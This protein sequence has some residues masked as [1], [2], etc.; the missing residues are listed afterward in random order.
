MSEHLDRM[1]QNSHSDTLKDGQTD[2][3]APIAIS[4]PLAKEQHEIRKGWFPLRSGTSEHASGTPAWQ[5]AIARWEMVYGSSVVA[6]FLAA[7]AATVVMGI[8]RLAWGVPSL[9][10]LVGER[11]LPL[12]PVDLFV[13]MLVFFAPDSKTSPLGLALLGQLILGTA[14]GPVAVKLRQLIAIRMPQAQGMATSPMQAVSRYQTLGT[15]LAVGSIAL[16]ELF[17]TVILFWPVLGESLLGNPVDQ[18]RAITIAACSVTFFTYALV[19]WIAGQWLGSF[20]TW[21][22]T[23]ILPTD[24]RG[25]IPE[26][27]PTAVRASDNWHRTIRPIIEHSANNSPAESP[28]T[29]VAGVSGAGLSGRRAFIKSGVTVLAVASGTFALQQV[30]TDVL[31]RSNLAYEGMITPLNGISAITPINEFYVVSKNV[32]D[33]SVIASHWQLELRGLIAEEH[34]WTYA[35]IQRLPSETRAITIQCISNQVGAGL[36]STGIWQGVELAT[37]LAQQ[38]GVRENASHVVFTSVDG[39][40][41]SLPLA[42][43]L[44]AKALLAW[45]VNGVALPPAHGFPLR[46]IVPGRY[47][48]QSPKWLTRI[49]LVDHPVKGFYQSQGWSDAPVPTTSRFDAPGTFGEANSHI[50]LAPVTVMGIAYAGT[51]GIQK[52]EVSTDNGLTWNM[53]TLTPP[54]SDQSWVIWQWVWRPPQVGTFQLVVRAVDGTGAPQIVDERSTV[55]DGAT[56]LQHITVQVG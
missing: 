10:E 20:H 55:P 21:Q 8:L 54:L 11:V 12:L 7:L 15:L 26:Q 33:P 37:L 40:V 32:L 13:R 29:G 23:D 39:Y 43:L 30:I 14:L 25:D 31:R 51:R 4:P 9:P 44:A 36:M 53:A 22:R 46:V 34:T 52:V 28:G 35:E 48:E 24:L 49:E 45:K 17:L 56:G 6:G 41:S 3:D 42:D 2:G 19:L 1:V 47:G 18:A 16:G 5:L 38:G 50:P 27:L